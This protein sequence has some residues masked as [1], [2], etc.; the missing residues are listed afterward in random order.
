MFV[1]ITGVTI[2]VT[3]GAVLPEL[4]DVPGEE[5]SHPLKIAVDTVKTKINFFE[6]NFVFVLQITLET[7]LKILLKIIAKSYR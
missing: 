5:E 2:G 1:A 3:T 7:V 4:L 6:I